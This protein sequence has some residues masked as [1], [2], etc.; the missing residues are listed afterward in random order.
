MSRLE[1]VSPEG[2]RVDG[3]RPGELR[4]FNCSLGL[5]SQADGSAMVEIG[6]TKC[7]A[8]VYGPKEVKYYLISAIEEVEYIAR[9]CAYQR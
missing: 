9:S 3:R 2:L 4:N 6:N 5:F 1:L 8:A 7:I